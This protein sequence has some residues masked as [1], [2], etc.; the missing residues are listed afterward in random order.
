MKKINITRLG[1]II[2][3]SVLFIAQKTDAQSL[4]ANNNAGSYKI[5]FQERVRLETWD[6]AVSL[7]RSANS[8]SSY[9][10]FKSS[11][12]GQW[13]AGQTVE[14]AAKI[15][16]EFRT[17]FA[18]ST[19]SFRMNEIFIDQLYLKWNTKNILEGTLTI[20]RQ[21]MSYGEGFV[22]L[23]GT[24]LDGSR[25]TYFN[26]VKYDWNINKENNLSFFALYV[27]ITDDLPVINGNDIE[28][29]FLVDGTW[30][31]A[32]QKENA[33]GVYYTGKFSWGGLQSYY[34]RKNYLDPKL[35]SGQIDANVNVIGGRIVKPLMKELNVTFEGAYQFGKYGSY[36]RNAYGG[37][38]YFDYKPLW[39]TNILPKTFT[40]GTIILSG[41]DPNTNNNE[42]WDPVF[43]RWPKWSDSYVYTYV[44]ESR[45]SNWSNLISIY[46]SFKFVFDEKTGFNFDYHHMLAPEDKMNSFTAGNGTLRGD[47]FIAKLIFEITKNLSGHLLYEHFNPGGYYFNNADSYNFGRVEFTVNL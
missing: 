46:A 15:T 30:G 11:V 7:L 1:L 24:P 41:D 16:N 6:N 32:E 21:N 39:N 43:S 42:G 14:I 19:N 20:G 35:S 9:M 29:S 27:P 4:D 36:D 17:Y 26:A 22:I 8:G 10:R 47:L 37:Y 40:F 3:V 25:S 31:L 13:Y 45:I 18:P 33:F 28:A 5:S 44:K 2:L 23:E 38:I 12:M 34:I